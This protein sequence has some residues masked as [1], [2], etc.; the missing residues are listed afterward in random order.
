M[1]KKILSS[2]VVLALLTGAVC[3]FIARADATPES[4]SGAVG[5]MT[6]RCIKGVNQFCAYQQ[7]N[8]EL[9][10]CTGKIEWGGPSTI[11]E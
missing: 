8:G 6:Y 2:L 9:T 3:N 11:I 10:L 5:E 1:K 4:C 7:V